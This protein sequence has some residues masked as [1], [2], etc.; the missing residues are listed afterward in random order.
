MGCRSRLLR[1]G[2]KSSRGVQA[3][4]LRALVSN[5]ALAAA[6]SASISAWPADALSG[7]TS[8]AES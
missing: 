8:R 6:I 2:A 4:P 7:S 5:A 1:Y 3:E